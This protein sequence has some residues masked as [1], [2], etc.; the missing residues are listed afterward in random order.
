MEGALLLLWEVRAWGV[1]GTV[2]LPC[3]PEFLACPSTCEYS[4]TAPAPRCRPLRWRA[5]PKLGTPRSL[6]PAS[7]ALSDLLGVPASSWFLRMSQRIPTPCPVFTRGTRV[8]AP[9]VSGRR[10]RC[11]GNNRGKG[12]AG[13]PG[14]LWW[15]EV[16]LC[17]SAA[18]LLGSLGAG[19]AE[20]P[21][22]SGPSLA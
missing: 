21:L 2:P 7:L 20:D 12:S 18:L 8:G 11:G 16:V 6:W 13:R 14:D 9:R 22:C 1:G 17:G 3:W 15:F 4:P 19:W 5:L 10:A